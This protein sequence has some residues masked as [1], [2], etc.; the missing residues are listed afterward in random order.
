MATAISFTRGDV[1]KK[2]K[3]TPSGI[4]PF[5]NPIKRGTDEQEQNGVTAPK[6]DARKYSNPKRFLF[7][8]KLRIFSIGKYVFTKFMSIETE[9]KRIKI[10]IES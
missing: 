2:A 10:L 3:V 5:T 8:R 7:V 4:P 6:R 9:Y 1:I